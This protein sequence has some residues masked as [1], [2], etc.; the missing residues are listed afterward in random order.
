MVLGI[1]FWL[2]IV[3]I[4]VYFI[5]RWAQ[6]E[7]VINNQASGLSSFERDDDS[8]ENKKRIPR[9]A[10][11]PVSYAP[12][13]GIHELAAQLRENVT[14]ESTQESPV[15]LGEHSSVV[16][17]HLKRSDFEAAEKSVKS[18]GDADGTDDADGADENASEQK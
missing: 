18:T 14:A 9:T 7:A 1:I 5:V 6:S 16:P 17:M 15:Y 13:E 4:L 11:S 2:V 3:G 8:E 10:G 12:Q